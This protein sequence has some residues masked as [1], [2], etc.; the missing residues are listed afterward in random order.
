MGLRLSS[1]LRVWGL[2]VLGGVKLRVEFYCKGFGLNVAARLKASR[3]LLD[4]LI[5]VLPVTPLMGPTAL[6]RAW[7]EGL[8]FCADSQVGG[9][10]D[11][12][13][14]ETRHQD[15]YQD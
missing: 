7:V 1:G 2:G 5:N 6:G 12:Q 14:L 9:V 11:H 13:K 15:N 8:R 3:P 10:G 4:G